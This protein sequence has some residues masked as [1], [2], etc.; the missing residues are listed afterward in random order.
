MKAALSAHSAPTAERRI[1]KGPL[2]FVLIVGAFLSLLNQTV[3]GVALPEMMKQFH[4]AASSAQWLTTG[5]MLVNG[6]LIPITA[7]LM[8][9]FTTRQLFISS[10]V[11]LLVGTVICS[12]APGFEVLLTG[13]LIQAAGAGI[14]MPLLMNVILEVFPPE[15]RGGAMGLIGL[16]MIF[17][18]AIGP[19]LAGLVIEHFSWRW[20]FYGMLPL[21][22]LVIVLSFKYLVNISETSRPRVDLFSVL[23]STLGF[24]GLLY[25][26]SSA[27]GKGWDDAEVL[28][29]IAIGLVLLV[30]FCLRQLSS[31]EPLLDL[32]VFRYRA[33]SVTAI[34]N[35]MVTMVMYADMILLPLYLQTSRGYT[36]LESGELMLPGAL[37]MGLM[38]PVAG[39]LYDRFGAK[40]LAVFGLLITIGGIVGMSSLGDD[41]SYGYIMM[42]N[43]L[44]RLGMSFLM[45]PVTTAGLNA[46]PGNLNAH[47]TAAS[48]TTRQVAGAI[49]TALLVTILSTRTKGHAED[50]MASG[51]SLSKQQLVVEASIQGTSDAYLFVVGLAALALV[52][53]LFLTNRKS[54]AVVKKEAS[55]A[56][57]G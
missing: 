13:R 17:A 53:T 30:V 24:G 34:V 5:F 50:L 56:Q 40:L 27:G 43:V 1:Q 19:T 48:N 46:L 9:R 14:I 12:V 21:V 54:A 15:N 7:Y 31:K 49:G 55:A 38:S 33:F 18:P 47:G 37:L 57:A 28:G 36:V 16:A 29:S 42:M 35:V 6:I 4:I 39:K 20:M 22:A 8:K 52:A 2:L 3:M 25:G 41:T 44:V 51:A 26:L 11:L 10:M 23:L 45:M 32:R